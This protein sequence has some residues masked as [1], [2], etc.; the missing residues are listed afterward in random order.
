MDPGAWE[1][2]NRLLDEALDLPPGDRARWLDA[3]APEWDPIKPRLRSLL[4]H[5]PSIAAEGFLGTVAKFEP[6]VLD[7]DDEA[8]GLRAAGSDVGPYRLVRELG[9]G[10][11]GTVWYA[12]RIDGLVKRPVALKLPRGL[13]PHAG[14]FER[15]ARERDILASLN[16]PHIARLYD[17]GVTRD[18]QP[19][20][21]LEVVDGLPIDRYVADRRLDV[22]ARLRLFLQVAQAVAH[23]HSNLIIH[24]DLKPSNILVTAEGDVKLLDFGIA[25]LLEEGTTRPTALTEASGRPLTPEYASPE[26]VAGA[27][28]TVAA[29]TYSLGVVL[30]ELLA[31]VRPYRLRRDSRAVL[32]DAILQADITRPSDAA[33][34]PSSRRV[35]RGDLDTIILK[36]L[37]LKAADRYV[38]V[39]AFADDVERYLAGQPVAARTASAWYRA[40]RFVRRNAVAT[41]ASAAVLTAIVTGAGVALWQARVAVAE[42]QRAEEVK[43]FITGIFEDAD[44][45]ENAGGAMTVVQLLQEARDR[46]GR[47]S[48]ARPE[49][50]IELLSLVGSSLNNLHEV[51]PAE[52]VLSETVAEASRTLGTNHPLTLHARTLLALTHRFVGDTTRLKTELAELLP[53]LRASPAAS[54]EDLV[55]A[56]ESAAIVAIT[57]GRYPDAETA[58]VEMVETASAALG[59]RHVKTLDARWMLVDAYHQQSKTAPALALAETLY[60]VTLEVLGGNTRAPRVIEVREMYARVLARAG[61]LEE[62]IAHQAGVLADAIEVF[63]ASSVAVGF[64]ASNLAGLRL[65]AGDLGPALANADQA[66]GV[67]ASVPGLDSVPYAVTLGVRGSILLAARQ[68]DEA[69]PPLTRA[70]EQLDR[71]RG[72]SHDSTRAVRLERTRAVGYKGNV[73]DALRDMEALA[74]PVETSAARDRPLHL[75]GVLDRLN[76]NPSNALR[77]QQEAL[78]SIAPGRRAERTRMEV[79][80]EIGLNH[81]ELGNHDQAIS[82]LTE[83]LALFK[84]L[85]VH[86]TPAR[87]DALVGLGRATMGQGDNAGALSFLE[88]AHRFWSGFDADNRW[89]GEAALWLGLCHAAL[90]RA[91]DA[92]PMLARATRILSRSPFQSDAALLRTAQAR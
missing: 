38:T 24:R 14:L 51:A 7:A 44:I 20:L 53:A 92:R 48:G 37:E 71:L 40:S 29:D 63:G 76:G 75:R 82:T 83:A 13:R 90:G 62:G 26:Q 47:L 27:P 11:M 3:L 89:A 39:S 33:T 32:E 25:K 88:E 69:L 28:L 10:G 23:A 5:A 22:R 86:Q 74:T 81:V 58:A 65:D 60:P 46:V 16:H 2:L 64:F 55:E 21:A 31:G 12:E 91:D 36:A 30:Y 61:K 17:A 87:A 84:V 41:G 18:G 68:A 8:A 56:L 49:V 9:H 42:Q 15:I 72:A 1:A 59:D 54:P 70:V 35:L 80:T 6:D 50:R 57:E 73:R 45:Y 4:A 79:L 85:Q 67:M 34:D 43:E 66:L 52:K 19:Y 77:V 78:A